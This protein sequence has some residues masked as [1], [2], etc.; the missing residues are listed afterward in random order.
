M[1][2]SAEGAPRVLYDTA[3]IQYEPPYVTAWTRIVVPRTATLSNGVRYRSVQQKV[4]VDCTA[5]KW[6]VTY[7]EFFG[8]RDAS[9][10]PL[11]WD[12]V[13]REQWELNSAHPGSN[14][15]ALIRALC[16]TPRPW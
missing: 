14:G 6:G 1:G 7:S 4:A 15:D 10:V 8:T 11:Y 3:R 13:P 9:G 5:R 12:S 2:V 16:T